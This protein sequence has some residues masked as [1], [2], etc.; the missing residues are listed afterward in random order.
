V[1]NTV[2]PN[3]KEKRRK[4]KNIEVISAVITSNTLMTTSAANG[5]N[6]FEESQNDDNETDES[7]RNSRMEQTTESAIEVLGDNLALYD[8]NITT[9]KV[10]GKKKR[11]A[12]APIHTDTPVPVNEELATEN[13]EETVA[14]D[15]NSRKK[16]NRTKSNKEY[17]V[18]ELLL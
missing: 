8:S 7:S 10:S 2:T 3:T 17:S 6:I 15:S 1:V 4:R 16:T 18:G 12:S 5:D 14:E 11:R 9:S 13:G